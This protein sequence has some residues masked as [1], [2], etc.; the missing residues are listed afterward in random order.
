MCW[1]TFSMCDFTGFVGLWSS[2]LIYGFCLLCEVTWFGFCLKDLD[3]AN[4]CLKF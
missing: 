1:L 3:W 2:A 4:C